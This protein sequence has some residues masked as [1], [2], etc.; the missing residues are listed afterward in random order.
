MNQE[1]IQLIQSTGIDPNTLTEEQLQSLLTAY[2]SG[3]SG[4]M[5]ALLNDIAA[6]QQAQLQQPQ[7]PQGPSQEELLANFQGQPMMGVDPNQPQGQ[8]QPQGE[9][10]PMSIL[11]AGGVPPMAQEGMMPQG[12]PGMPPEQ[13]EQPLPPDTSTNPGYN[14]AQLDKEMEDPNYFNNLYAQLEQGNQHQPQGQEQMP[15][16]EPAKEQPPVMP[17]VEESA[18]AQ[19][20]PPVETTQ[21]PVEQP[22][23]E[24]SEEELMAMYNNMENPQGNTEVEP[25]GQE[26]TSLP[27]EFF[28]PPVPTKEETM[29]EPIETPT[30]EE[31]V[32][33]E[34]VMEEEVPAEEVME[35][36]PTEE[37][38]EEEP[39]KTVDELTDED[40]IAMYNN[41]EKGDITEEPIEESTEEI[42]V[43]KDDVEAIADE[44]EDIDPD[45][46]RKVASEDTADIEADEDID[47]DIMEKARAVAQ[48][49]LES[50]EE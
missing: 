39:V 38:I 47:A 2:K 17:P 41:L 14:N 8:V 27:P 25:E 28:E 13:Q 34:P 48:K 31:V 1:F 6:Q 12:Q 35:E 15:L 9:P 19:E 22:T 10:D 7:Q 36:E 49:L 4:Q 16:Q 37:T 26:T 33:E 42:T 43:S 21:P 45:I 40:I 44:E 46:L 18:S 11:A 24:P 50:D 30:E 3:N 20:Q 32:A 29:N 5:E 23:P